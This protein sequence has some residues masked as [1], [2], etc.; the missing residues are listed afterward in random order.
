[1]LKTID[2]IGG[3]ELNDSNKKHSISSHVIK[4]RKNSPRFYGIQVG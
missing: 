1:M 2:L 4:K 3:F